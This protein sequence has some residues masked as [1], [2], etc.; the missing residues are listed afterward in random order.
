MNDGYVHSILYILIKSDFFYNLIIR[1]K[2]VEMSGIG[3][4]FQKKR[5]AQYLIQQGFAKVQTLKDGISA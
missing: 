2:I 4:L 3:L 5:A 1:K